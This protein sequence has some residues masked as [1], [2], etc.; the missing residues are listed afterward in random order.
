VSILGVEIG[1]TGCAAV[2]FGINGEV[3]ARVVRDYPLHHPESG[4]M[5][6]DA[7]QVMAQV[8]AAIAEAADIAGED[9]PV[10]V[11]CAAVQGETTV[12]VDA[13]GTPLAPAL[14]T[15]DSR[16]TPQSEWVAREVGTE[17]I[18]QITG[19]PVHPMHSLAKILWLKQRRPELTAQTHQYIGFDALFLRSLGLPAYTDHSMAG[20][21]MLL[22]IQ[23]KAY[24]SDLLDAGGLTSDQ[25]PR[26]ARA[27]T[28]VGTLPPSVA[29]RLHLPTG[30]LVVLGGHD[31]ACA[32]LG[33]GALEPGMAM[34]AVGAVEC[35]AVTLAAPVTNRAML[36]NHYACYPHVIPERYLTLAYNFTG[37][38]LLRWYRDT[39]GM[40]EDE[41]ALES[42]MGFPDVL[43][44]KASREPSPV[45][46]LPHFTAAGTPWLD[47]R[48]R[49]AIVGLTLTTPKAHIIKGL[50][51]GLAY[52]LRLNLDRLADAGITVRLLRVVGTGARTPAWLQL[53]ADVLNR[54]VMGICS[55]DAPALGAAHLAGVAAGHFR[56]LEDAVHRT[57]CLGPRTEPHP[58]D[59]ARYDRP[60]RL[61]QQLYP[62]L[63][64]IVQ[65]M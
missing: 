47:P 13:V 32:A 19:L 8:H 38:S 6:V 62:A 59:A 26:L 21:T 44:A 52:E 35:L 65:E 18:L 10:T 28:K 42:G 55:P 24:A 27:G 39:F 51:D 50:F 29:R 22:D 34:N 58:D 48:A 45:L 43:L 40:H 49:G 5:E 36:D 9:D 11:L 57:I 15:F 3:L 12:P 20:R 31:Q 14:T 2:I 30:V 33:C 54:H 53:K 60:Y 37:G 23:L 63:R 64:G 7:A 4:A 46:V 41:E 25:L 1:T 61:Y 56:D 16:P 17:R